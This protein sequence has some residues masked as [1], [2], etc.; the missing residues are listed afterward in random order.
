MFFTELT[1]SS[2][3]C[4]LWTSR[5]VRE[6][7]EVKDGKMNMIDTGSEVLRWF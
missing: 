3:S 6:K 5:S 1:V 2:M 4:W 7:T